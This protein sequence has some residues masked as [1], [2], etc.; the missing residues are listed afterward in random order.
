MLQFSYDLLSAWLHQVT[1]SRPTSV[2]T[3]VQS[4]CFYS[5]PF[6]DAL[7]KVPP[8]HAFRP[9][10][11]GRLR[12]FTGK[13]SRGYY[14][15][16]HHK[17]CISERAVS[18]C[19]LLGVR[20]VPRLGVRLTGY[21]LKISQLRRLR[22]PFGDYYSKGNDQQEIFIVDHSSLIP[23]CVLCFSLKTSDIGSL[24]IFFRFV[25]LNQRRNCYFGWGLCLWFI[26]HDFRFQLK[27]SCCTLC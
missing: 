25:V 7:S 22:L 21:L 18:Y 9:L 13:H 3:K 14:E 26:E 6:P 8:R 1:V 20:R 24:C 27:F 12:H 2:A 10:F 11:I 4:I 16:V 17:M 23:S 15:N 19:S 5:C